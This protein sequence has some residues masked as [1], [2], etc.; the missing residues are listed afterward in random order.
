MNFKNFVIANADPEL[1]NKGILYTKEVLGSTGALSKINHNVDVSKDKIKKYKSLSE[2]GAK[3]K[4][5]ESTIHII[6]IITLIIVILSI[7]VIIAS[8]L[9]D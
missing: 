8:D 4:S 6:S 3:K 5:T 1:M 2:N 7:I 9:K